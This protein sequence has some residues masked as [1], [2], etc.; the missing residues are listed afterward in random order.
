M[1]SLTYWKK[2]TLRLLFVGTLLFQQTS[3]KGAASSTDSEEWNPDLSTL[4]GRIGILW[5]LSQRHP[6]ILS[7]SSNHSYNPL[8]ILGRSSQL[9]SYG[10]LKFGN[11]RIIL[12][13]FSRETEGDLIERWP[14][15]DFPWRSSEKFVET[16]I[17]E[18]SNIAD[19]P[20]REN[21]RVVSIERL[22]SPLPFLYVER[23]GLPLP[24]IVDPASPLA[25]NFRIYWIRTSVDIEQPPNGYAVVK[26]EMKDVRFR[27]IIMEI[28][29]PDLNE[30][31]VRQSIR[32]I[33]R[34]FDTNTIL[35]NLNEERALPKPSM[36]INLSMRRYRRVSLESLKPFSSKAIQ[37][38]LTNPKKGWNLFTTSRKN[39]Y[40][41]PQKMGRASL[42]D[43]IA[44]A[45]SILRLGNQNSLSKQK[46][47]IL[48]S[49]N[50]KDSDMVEFDRLRSILG[51]NGRM[52]KYPDAYRILQ[53]WGLST[54]RYP[55]FSLDEEAKRIYILYLHDPERF[56]TSEAKQDMAALGNEILRACHDRNRVG[57][58]AAA[59]I[60]PEILSAES[61]QRFA[62]DVLGKPNSI[63]AQ[64]LVEE[65]A[66][67]PHWPEPLSQ[68]MK[69]M[70]GRG[71]GIDVP[72]LK[73][74][75][76]RSD[77]E[78]LIPGYLSLIVGRG[79]HVA[80][81]NVASRIRLSDISTDEGRKIA[82]RLLT[83]RHVRETMLTQIIR[84]GIE[85]PE[86]LQDLRSVFSGT[87]YE[88][89]TNFHATLD[90][91]S[92]PTTTIDRIAKRF[93]SD[94]SPKIR[95][96]AFRYFLRTNAD[97]QT[98]RM[99]ML[100]LLTDSDPEL[101][102]GLAD[103]LVSLP[104]WNKSQDEAANKLLKSSDAQVR[105]KV[106]SCI[107]RQFSWS[108]N[109]LETIFILRSLIA[110]PDPE[111]RRIVEQKLMESGAAHSI[112]VKY[113]EYPL[114]PSDVLWFLDFE[115]FLVRAPHLLG[116]VFKRG[117]VVQRNT[118]IRW[119]QAAPKEEGRS[120]FIREI[121]RHQSRLALME[122][123]HQKPYEKTFSSLRAA[124]DT[125]ETLSIQF[126]GRS[127]PGNPMILMQNGLRERG[128]V[129]TLTEV[130]NLLAEDKFAQRFPYWPTT[131][132][133]TGVM[134]SD[135]KE[136]PKGQLDLVLATIESIRMRRDVRG[137]AIEIPAIAILNDLRDQG[138]WISPRQ[139]SDILESNAFSVRI[140]ELNRGEK[141]AGNSL[142]KIIPSVPLPFEIEP[143]PGYRSTTL[144]V[145]QKIINSR[146]ANLGFAWI[147]PDDIRANWG[148]RRLLLPSPRTVSNEISVVLNIINEAR[149]AYGL[150]KVPYVRYKLPGDP[151]GLVALGA[152]AIEKASATHPQH[153]VTRESIDQELHQLDSALQQRTL[154]IIHSKIGLNRIIEHQ[155]RW[156]RLGG[157]AEIP[158]DSL[159]PIYAKPREEQVFGA[160]LRAA[161]K[162]KPIGGTIFVTIDDIRN[163][164]PGLTPELSQ[165]V[166]MTTHRTPFVADRELHNFR[167]A[168]EGK[169]TI[170]LLES[171]TTYA[172][173][174]IVLDIMK[175]I[176]KDRGDGRIAR[177][178][179]MERVKFMRSPLSQRGL[180]KAL[181]QGKADP[182]QRRV[183]RALQK[184]TLEF[185]EEL[186]KE[187]AFQE[188]INGVNQARKAH[189]KLAPL[190]LVSR[191][192][193]EI[194][195]VPGSDPQVDDRTLGRSKS[196]GLTSLGGRS[197][198]ETAEGAWERTKDLF[199]RNPDKGGLGGHLEEVP[200]GDPRLS[201][202]KNPWLRFMDGKWN[203]FW[204]KGNRQRTHLV[205]E[206]VH[207]RQLIEIATKL[208]PSDPAH[209]L[210]I[211]GQL[212]SWRRS[213]D[214]VR[215]AQAEGF[216]R[217]LELQSAKITRNYSNDELSED[218]MIRIN[219]E[220]AETERSERWTKKIF[221][222]ITKDPTSLPKPARP[223]KF[224]E[225]KILLSEGTASL[226]TGATLT[227]AFTSLGPMTFAQIM[228]N[229]RKGLTTGDGK[230][231]EAVLDALN[232]E[233][234]VGAAQFGTTA[235]VVGTMYDGTVG[236]FVQHLD[237]PLVNP[238]V[239]EVLV[240]TI[241]TVLPQL[242]AGHKPT[243]K[244]IYATIGGFLAGYAAS[245]AFRSS[246]QMAVGMS[247]GA[248]VAEALTGNI[249]LSIVTYYVMFEVQQFLTNVILRKWEVVQAAAEKDKALYQF[250]EHARGKGEAESFSRDF[251]QVHQKYL[252]WRASTAL[253]PVFEVQQ[254]FAAKER[255][256]MDRFLG[257][258]ATLDAWAHDKDIHFSQRGGFDE[259]SELA[260]A[261]V[262]QSK[263][264]QQKLGR[265][266]TPSEIFL[267]NVDG[268]SEYRPW[269]IRWIRDQIQ[270]MIIAKE[271]LYS[272]R[273][274][275]N[276][277][278]MKDAV[279]KVFGNNELE[280]R[281]AGKKD[282]LYPVLSLFPETILDNVYQESW[283]MDYLRGE[284]SIRV[285]G[286]IESW[287]E[288]LARERQVQI[289]IRNALGAV[290]PLSSD[291]ILT[292]TGYRRVQLKAEGGKWFL[293]P[294]S[295]KIQYVSEDLTEDDINE[296]TG[297][298]AMEYHYDA[299]EAKAR[300]LD[301]EFKYREQLKWKKTEPSTRW[302]HLQ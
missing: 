202:G 102:R 234:I 12:A 26:M 127:F 59:Y 109:P 96:A 90:E 218:L 184:I 198:L 273:Y 139:L 159:K 296:V 185:L 153:S 69:S 279:D 58:R 113:D 232:P 7:P 240:M 73:V 54:H 299:F 166:L 38:V 210:W 156:L 292:G 17:R 57:Y 79:S 174:G 50:I 235:A 94:R 108:E 172:A 197:I 173:R 291:L 146:E 258:I 211:L 264:L 226:K 33:A 169:P 151:A 70:I 10:P 175:S 81:E 269:I 228:M 262:S 162:K 110:D 253:R 30:A 104:S 46:D 270:R 160:Y 91:F 144:E 297:G 220:V 165:L 154:G 107:G 135:A 257:A 266:V 260:R 112:L 191:F 80:R 60:F 225:S 52:D 100:N 282:Q 200:I 254:E 186:P 295:S 1:R 249:V 190:K 141:V 244:E 227:G 130:V 106:A 51:E 67:L 76:S 268:H 87:R 125:A 95:L 183:G 247:E 285:R 177:E 9:P 182:T 88:I 3:A 85:N 27:P 137:M 75:Q 263:E 222:E 171:S 276:R 194:L 132:P 252:G 56:Q 43:R 205:Q 72:L 114:T 24:K 207:A 124:I 250:Y 289:K 251:S 288:L 158:L 126:E 217:R 23:L 61:W 195:R 111:V 25:A 230:L 28:K 199:E 55:F 35:V 163:E 21:E 66:Y 274:Y 29:G 272:E 37:I 208:S 178:D 86:A 164:I 16:P 246:V 287:L 245:S 300:S 167:L 215:R 101:Q 15:W 286:V 209:G 278:Q 32:M 36:W 128:Y 192:D 180:A 283:L 161:E 103:W 243:E 8:D 237:L 71:Y 238:I 223:P 119:Y 18:V 92:A 99:K 78:K 189:A 213:S 134:I 97:F 123:I 84:L 48:R 221:E 22:S 145:A 45:A 256:I 138:Y 148:H 149:K 6:Q 179:V 255:V 284:E 170:T 116:S 41:D 229:F 53:Q 201:N 39:T 42:P 281:A 20:L 77:S 93:L 193:D 133:A 277:T 49:L 62:E 301:S 5:S 248:E 40:V 271:K 115:T 290:A 121:E 157:E 98:T 280:M 206:Y 267:E 214:S 131:P 187:Y 74:L 89:G 212:E 265:K 34:D 44:F 204:P 2:S 65:S 188:Q 136:V 236:N 231:L 31:D 82:K 143:I 117:S 155:N 120:R 239:R 14:H 140:E 147:K 294:A 293:V 152:S 176:A 19:I 105:G 241:A 216:A 68:L 259:M 261:S 168:D 233:K 298:M 242:M 129:L 224:D 150:P 203:L 63:A 13:S 275:S 118:V 219:H 11:N 142:I 181:R 4:E 196:D 64:V 122:R 302:N 83:D 47:E